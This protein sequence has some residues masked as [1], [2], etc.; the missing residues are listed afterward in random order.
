MR[1]LLGATLGLLLLAALPASAQPRILNGFA[2]GGTADVLVRL[3]AEQTAGTFGQRAVVENR[4]GA[5]GFIAAE[6]VARGPTDGSVVGLCVMGMMAVS[7]ELPGARLPI[8]P[9]TD[10]AGVA[11]VALSPYGLVV[12]AQSPHR[13]LADLLRASRMRAGAVSYASVGVGSAPHL[14]GA[15]LALRAGTEMVHVPYRG[16]APAVLDVVAGRADFLMISLGDVSQQLR[17]GE[18]RLL[19]LGDERRLPGIPDAPNL[20]ATLPGTEAY[21]WFALCG[22]HGITAEGRA[23]WERA[24][25]AAQ[26]DPAFQERLAQLGLVSLFEDGPALDRRIEADRRKW[27][28]VV[29]AAN[30]QAQ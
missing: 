25:Q 30:I 13:S 8:E 5:N 16:G 10:L 19:A 4:T 29:R 12:G 28:E 24:V 20:S 9:R 26:A 15:L 11:L 1:R 7:P 18:L 22:P 14:F 6:A 27:G 23:R 21:S 17:S 3:L 2:P